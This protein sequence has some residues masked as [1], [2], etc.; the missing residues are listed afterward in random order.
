MKFKIPQR[1]AVKKVRKFF[2]KF[3]KPIVPT[4]ELIKIV[5]ESTAEYEKEI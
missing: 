5:E 2:E 4:E 1:D 3:R